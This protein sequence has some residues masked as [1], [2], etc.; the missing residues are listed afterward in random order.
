MT[1]EEKKERKEEIIQSKNMFHVLE[2][3][4]VKVKRR[5]CCCI[6][7][8]EKNPSMKVFKD[9]VQCFVCGQNWNVF[10]VV[11]QL[12]GCDFNTTFDLLGG[13][14]KPSW[15]SYATAKRAKSIRKNKL[16]LA[17]L[18]NQ[19]IKDQRTKV[20]ALRDL[21]RAEKPYSEIWCN[22]HNRLVYEEYILDQMIDEVSK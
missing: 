20:M 11:M 6:F 8:Q 14:D 17:N 15:K 21:I 5:M 12:T 1:L 4:G 2:E 18:K 19:K 7:H 13:N 3:H 22:S 9:G 10:D 16:G